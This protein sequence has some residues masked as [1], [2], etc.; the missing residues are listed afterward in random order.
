M[1]NAGLRVLAISLCSFLRW[2]K[3]MLRALRSSSV[4]SQSI[5]HESNPACTKRSR[6]CDMSS[7]VKLASK[8]LMAC[9]RDSCLR[10]NVQRQV[11]LPPVPGHQG[12]R[13]DRSSQDEILCSHAIGIDLDRTWPSCDDDYPWPFIVIYVGEGPRWDGNWQDLRFLRVVS[14]SLKAWRQNRKC[15][16]DDFDWLEGTSPHSLSEETPAGHSSRPVVDGP[17]LWLPYFC[18]SIFVSVPLPAYTLLAPSMP[19]D[20]V[21]YDAARA[22]L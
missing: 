16:R 13:Y 6:Y 9:V 20:L 17:F 18:H 14:Q 3:S 2:P 21:A 11:L 15:L 8:S 7:H 19:S 4:T 12:P 10:D 22:C 5:S 1:T